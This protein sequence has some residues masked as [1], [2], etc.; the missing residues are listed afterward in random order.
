MGTKESEIQSSV[1]SL[2]AQIQQLDREFQ[3]KVKTYQTSRERSRKQL[4]K[5]KEEIDTLN[6]ES[7]SL[8]DRRLELSEVINREVGNNQIYRMAMWWSGEES[9]AKVAKN[10]VAVVALIWFGSLAALV[11]LMGVV[12]ALAS[13]VIQDPRIKDTGSHTR[14]SALDKFLQTAR[15]LKADQRKALRRRK[16]IVEVDRVVFTEI[17]VEIVKKEYVHVPF[18][19]NDEALLNISQPNRNKGKTDD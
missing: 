3:T 8:V 11:A 16:E 4:D 9:A 2:N 6:K 10:T 17:P 18:Y 5:Q 12:L 14:P 19:T 7:G 13:L 15:R 1:N